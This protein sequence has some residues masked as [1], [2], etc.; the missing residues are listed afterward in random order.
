M[1]LNFFKSIAQILKNTEKLLKMADANAQA[2]TDLQTEATA[3]SAAI[4]TLSQ[5]FSDGVTKLEALIATLQAAGGNA[6]VSAQLE[7]IVASMKTGRAS[8]ESMSTTITT[9]EAKEGV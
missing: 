4:A 9:E 3:D 1:I 6:D 2:V 5:Q 7:A 8:V